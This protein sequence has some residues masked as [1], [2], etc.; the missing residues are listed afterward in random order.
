MTWWPTSGWV[1]P[2]PRNLVTKLVIF[3]LF[4]LCCTT[5]A[6]CGTAQCHSGREPGFWDTNLLP[7]MNI[8]Y[9]VTRFHKRS[10]PSRIQ[11]ERQWDMKVVRLQIVPSMSC[12]IQIQPLGGC[13]PTTTWTQSLVGLLIWLSV[14]PPHELNH[15]ED[16]WYEYLSYHHMNSITGRTVDPSFCPIT[17]R[18]QP[19]GGHSTYHQKN[20]IP[21]RSIWQPLEQ[22]CHQTTP[23]Y[24]SIENV[25]NRDRKCRPI[26]TNPIPCPL[27][28]VPWS[29]LHLQNR[30]H[31]TKRNE[32]DLWRL[33]CT[34]YASPFFFPSLHA[35]IV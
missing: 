11:M 20:S 3:F 18:T 21:G 8:F 26:P 28:T 17:T 5:L 16:F 13:C 35:S 24:P 15:W 2:A 7:T 32:L 33:I 9:F 25:F 31:K 30:A 19:V 22:S 1:G 12:T 6:N 29:L 4:Q 27:H 10:S 23:H 34:N 14:L